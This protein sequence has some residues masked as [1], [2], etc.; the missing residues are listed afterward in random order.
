MSDYSDCLKA[1]EIGENIKATDKLCAFGNEIA[2]FNMEF[3]TSI[4]IIT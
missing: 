2:C 4:N 1:T 3:I